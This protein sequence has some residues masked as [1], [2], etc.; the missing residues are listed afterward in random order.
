[1]RGI[2]NSRYWYLYG[3]LFSFIIPF[4][5]LAQSVKMDEGKKPLRYLESKNK[6]ITWVFEDVIGSD[7]ILSG[8]FKG[9]SKNKIRQ[10]IHKSD[11][12]DFYLPNDEVF[13]GI[14][15]DKLFTYFTDY[16]YNKTSIHSYNFRDLTKINTSEINGAKSVSHT[17]NG[18][19][20][21]SDAMEGYGT[22][23]SI[24][25][26]SLKLIQRIVPSEPFSFDI[27]SSSENDLAIIIQHE[28]QKK[29]EIYF[30][31]KS[32]NIL[33]KIQ[34]PVY[35]SHIKAKLL[36][37]SNSDL[38]LSGSETIM[39]IKRNGQLGWLKQQVPLYSEIYPIDDENILL[40]TYNGFDLMNALSGDIIWRKTINHIDFFKDC[41]QCFLKPIDWKINKETIGILYSLRSRTTPE[42]SPINYFVTITKQ[43]QNLSSTKMPEPLIGLFTVSDQ[44]MLI[45]NSKVTKHE[46]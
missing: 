45:G 38:L 21:L 39:R 22:E 37:G 13:L 19:I 27:S 29:I 30:I 25:D 15:D 32:G 28:V 6:E 5:N 33:S 44:F 17:E 20:L 41:I 43:G 11:G 23:L 4:F 10:S 9:F 2:M 46:K 1:M 40:F 12:S 7:I 42:D 3:A 31:N 26:E 34:L 36:K 14:S 35:I 16:N 18:L 24:Y 8:D